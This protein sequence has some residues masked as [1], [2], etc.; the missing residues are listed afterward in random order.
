MCPKDS[1]LPFDDSAAAGLIVD[2]GL[3]TG[4][5]LMNENWIDVAI[6]LLFAPAGS[7]NDHGP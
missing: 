3:S 6:L 5:R 2:H 4:D 7:C 1:F